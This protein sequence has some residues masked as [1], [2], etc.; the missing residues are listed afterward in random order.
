MA[1]TH[2]DKNIATN[3]DV[4]CR[5]AEVITLIG[6]SKTWVAAYQI[7]NRDNL[8]IQPFTNNTVKSNQ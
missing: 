1:A 7:L 3:R 8:S 2:D 5:S 6:T 4:E